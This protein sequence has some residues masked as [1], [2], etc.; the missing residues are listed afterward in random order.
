MCQKLG[1][2]LAWDAGNRSGVGGV[3]RVPTMSETIEREG[4]AG[5]GEREKQVKILA[6]SIYREL[7]SNGYG[8]REIVA[9]STELLELLTNDFRPESAK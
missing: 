8:H 2:P 5:R 1:T 4:T 6:K 9:L 3:R 7:K